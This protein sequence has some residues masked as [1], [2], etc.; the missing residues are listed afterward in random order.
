M[1]HLLQYK[2]KFNIRNSVYY[3]KEN[4]KL[5]LGIKFYFE[6]IGFNTSGI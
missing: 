3:C 6:M 4:E 2:Q 1:D 5:S